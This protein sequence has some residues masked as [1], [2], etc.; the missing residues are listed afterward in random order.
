MKIDVDTSDF[1]ELHSYLKTA[2]PKKWRA[3]QTM[4][5]NRAA[6]GSRTNVMGYFHRNMLVRNNSFLKSRIRVKKSTGGRDAILGSVRAA[7]HTG[8]AEQEGLAE[9][10]REKTVTLASR[11]GRKSKR[12]PPKFRMKKGKARARPTDFPGR[13]RRQR[14]NTMLQELGRQRNQ[15]PFVLFGHRKLPSGLWR[16][17][18]GSA[19]TRKLVPLQIFGDK[20]A[21]V[22]KSLWMR[23]S[24][25][26][27]F[28]RLDR[29][30][31]WSDI[32]NR[33]KA[34]SK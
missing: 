13:T 22:R 4:W 6:F 28:D 7:R 33:L 1:E 9:D 2:G 25:A 27:Y 11:G 10:K 32:A 17:G 19:A 21:K 23:R 8:W 24:T 30:R 34:N 20:P 5:L 12:M 15:K 31:A 3:A 26:R 14:A 16:F 18:P 29:R